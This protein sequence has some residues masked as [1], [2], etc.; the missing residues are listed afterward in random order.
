MSRGNKQMRVTPA[1][2][3]FLRA[4]RRLDLK[5]RMALVALLNEYGERADYIDVS[6][7]DPADLAQLREYKDLIRKLDAEYAD[8]IYWK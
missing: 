3:K 4:L 7:R 2:E 5:P 6:S 1:E 8:P